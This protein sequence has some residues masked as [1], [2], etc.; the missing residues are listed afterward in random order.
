MA[1][2]PKRRAP[3]SRRELQ[4]RDQER[5][6]QSQWACMRGTRLRSA[7]KIPANRL[8]FG[9][10]RLIGLWLEKAGFRIGERVEVDVSHG[11]LVL[12]VEKSD[13]TDT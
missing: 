12:T 10:N 3:K 2:K 1:H 9:P 4:I 13:G 5:L 11:R 8:R 7:P 6:S